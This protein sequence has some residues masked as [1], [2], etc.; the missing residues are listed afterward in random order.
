MDI[1][2]LVTLVRQ[3]DQLKRRIDDL[4]SKKKA[5][6]KDYDRIRNQTLPDM[7]DDSE[8]SSVPVKGLG[9]AIIFPMFS[10]KT[11]D[12]Y[13]L[14]KWLQD[15]DHGD[16]IVPT[17]NSSTLTSFIKEQV[18]EGNIEL[19]DVATFLEVNAWSQARI[20]RK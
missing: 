15:N 1:K 14:H 12:R 16:L 6:Q 10:V 7:M 17:V 8:L 13:S 11:T 20:V 3:M 19:A 9:Q 5:L 18:K 2:E 4:D